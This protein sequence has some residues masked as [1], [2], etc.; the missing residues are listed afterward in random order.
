VAALRVFITGASSGLG[1]A[2]ALAYAKRGAKLGILG[3]NRASLAL[4][5]DVLPDA[6]VVYEA[7]VRDAAAMRAAAQDFL[8]RHGGVDVVIANAGVSV[9]TAAE[10]EDD[11]AVL[12]ET[13]ATNVVGVAN[14]LQ[15]FI[16]AMRGARRGKLVGIASVA[17]YRGMRGS[18]AYCASKA[19]C[20]SWLES[21]RVELR[22]TGVE[23]LTICPGYIATPMTAGNPF[24]MPFLMSAG[25]AAARVMSVID[26][27]YAYSVIPWQMAIIARIL[28]VL[29]NAVFDRVSAR[30]PRKPRRERGATPP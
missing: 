10:A 6:P 16:G 21:T 29:P 15:P 11:N 22:D 14:T 23:V 18:G 2:L 1:R 3:R 30:S 20:I 27:G 13:L 8:G 5:A 7:D 9:G 28:R 12:A 26:A 17:G 19:A 25:T 24:R 4:V